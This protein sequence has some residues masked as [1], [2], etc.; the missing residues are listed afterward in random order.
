MQRAH[1]DA[2]RKSAPGGLSGHAKLRYLEC[3]R[4]G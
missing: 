3:L 2:V 1:D 4:N